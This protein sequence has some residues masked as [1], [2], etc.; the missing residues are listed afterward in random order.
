MARL[1]ARTALVFSL[2]LAGCGDD[3]SSPSPTPTLVTSG[4]PITSLSGAEDSEKLYRITIA[5]GATELLVT[6][7]GGTGDVDMVVNRGAA[8][9]PTT[10]N[11]CEEFGFDNDETCAVTNPPAGEWYILLIGAEGGYSGVTLT[12][13][14]T[15][16]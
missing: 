13:T 1:L 10:N 6:T 14:V 8:P 7:R 9:T 16:P 2:V 11:S 12:A 4:T 3:P 15:R 5:S